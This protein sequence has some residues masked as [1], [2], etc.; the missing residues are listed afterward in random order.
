MRPKLIPLLIFLLVTVMAVPLFML[1]GAGKQIEA[2]PITDLDVGPGRVL[3]ITVESNTQRTLSL[4]YHVDV[5]DQPQIEHAFFGTLPRT[6]PPP[7]FVIYTAEAGDLI[8]IAQATVPD[9]I[10]I[11]HDFAAGE[12]WPM[13]KVTYKDIDPQHIYPYY[14]EEDSIMARGEDQFARLVQALPDRELELLRT[15][16]T[17]PLTVPVGLADTT[18]PTDAPPPSR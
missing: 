18:V 12:S 11:L 16:G 7:G 9:R 5:D 13:R 17:R 3:R 8:G 10:I 4:H 6:S 15:M 1:L 14:E 2:A